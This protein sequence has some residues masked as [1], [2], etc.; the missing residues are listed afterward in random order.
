MKICLS[1]DP[2]N[3]E[4][5]L[6]NNRDT[7]RAGLGALAHDSYCLALISAYFLKQTKV[8]HW[9]PT[10]QKKMLKKNDGFAVKQA[11]REQ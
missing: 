4:K 3:A 6:K 7:Q 11:S 2:I 5:I 8:A 10:S 1:W 9:V